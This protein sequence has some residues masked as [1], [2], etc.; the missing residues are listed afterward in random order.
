MER[1]LR[2][3]FCL[4]PTFLEATVRQFG[5]KLKGLAEVEKVM[6]YIFYGTTIWRADFF[7]LL[8]TLLIPCGELWKRGGSV[9]RASNVRSKD[10]RFEPRLRQEHP[11]KL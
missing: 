1:P 5:V 9:Y 2:V 6:R 7:F 4:V 3:C 8:K 11:K 10:Q